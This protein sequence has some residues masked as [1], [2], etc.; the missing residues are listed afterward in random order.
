MDFIRAHQK[1]TKINTLYKRDEKGKIMYGEFSRPEFG[2]LYNNKWLAFE[3]IDGTNMSYYYDGHEMQIHGKTE[4]DLM[5]SH[6]L[7]KMKSIL[8]IEKLA[9]VFPIKYDENGNE[10]PFMVRIYGE[11]YGN[12]IQKYGKRYIS[13]D[14]D[15]IVFDININGY[16]LEWNAVVDLCNKLNLKHVTL[17]GEMTI[18]EAEDM[19]IKGFTSLSS[20]DKDLQ[21]EGLVLRP[22]IQLFN[23]MGE[24][25]MVKIKRR[26]YKTAK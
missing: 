2:Y 5:P 18:K 24:R 15:F 23:R 25:I 20:E 26:D 12:K 4:N 10:Q 6:L 13:N 3:K 16:W 7:K 22:K 9:E 8:T 19:V 1:Y 17:I 21:A 11:G 14:T